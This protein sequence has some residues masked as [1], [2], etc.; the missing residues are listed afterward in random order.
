M[1]AKEA[2]VAC[3]APGERMRLLSLEE[4]DGSLRWS[5]LVHQAPGEWVALSSGTTAPQESLVASARALLTSR[6]FAAD[7]VEVPEPLLVELLEREGKGE[8]HALAYL[9]DLMDPSVRD[10]ALGQELPRG[11]EAPPDLD[12]LVSLER[13]TQEVE[14]TVEG[15]SWTA[16][17]RLPDGT[18]V[19]LTAEPEGRDERAYHATATIVYPGGES[20]TL[21]ISLSGEPMES[22]GPLPTLDA[23]ADA[24]R[25]SL[26]S[27]ALHIASQ[28]EERERRRELTESREE[29][30][31]RSIGGR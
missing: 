19:T 15:T 6:G 16:S 23:A 27:L 2:V 28:R 18:S 22:A 11:V 5:E 10:A 20:E 14:E 31:Q 7:A 1:D 9:L 13:A 12:A 29:A 4:A 8:A 26:A 3:K 17:A 24:A 21:G 30:R 25:A